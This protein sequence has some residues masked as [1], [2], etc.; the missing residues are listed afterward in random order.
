MSK[1]ALATIVFVGAD[2]D[3]APLSAALRAAGFGVHEPATEA[4]ALDLLARGADLV[5]LG[6]GLGDVGVRDLCQRSRAASPAP[7]LRLGSRPA[8]AG[9]ADGYLATPVDPADLLAQVSGLLRLRR[10]EADLLASEAR[11]R[12]IL[13]NAPV[14]AYVKD[15]AGR[16]LL[17]NRRWEAAF[18]LGRDKVLGRNV[19]EIHPP[20]RAAALLANERLAL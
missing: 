20:E 19:A 6:A 8:G 5:L 4:E 18:R 7:V 11:L 3:Q 12:D 9:D 1:P 13:D 16:Y 2:A 15:L 14:I 17:V 10:A